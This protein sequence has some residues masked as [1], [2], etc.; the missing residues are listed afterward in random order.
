MVSFG[1]FCSLDMIKTRMR[2][3]MHPPVSKDCAEKF[4]NLSVVENS[5][6]FSSRIDSEFNSETVGNFSEHVEFNGNIVG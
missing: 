4:D 5:M 6:P 2:T 1:N 3:L